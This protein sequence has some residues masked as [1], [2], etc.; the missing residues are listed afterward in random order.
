L[1]YNCGAMTR[2]EYSEVVAAELLEVDPYAIV[3]ALAGLGAIAVRL[4]LRPWSDTR[5]NPPDRRPRAE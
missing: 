2:A 1:Q 4:R 5:R 3:D